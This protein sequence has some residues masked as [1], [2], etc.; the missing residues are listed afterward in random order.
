MNAFC[1]QLILVL[2]FMR[3][4]L[5]RR[6][7]VVDNLSELY[8]CWLS[9]LSLFSR[10]SVSSS[11]KSSLHNEIGIKRN[12]CNDVSPLENAKEENANLNTQSFHIMDD[13]DF[14]ECT[15]TVNHTLNMYIHC[16]FSKNTGLKSLY[17]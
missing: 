8:M 9:T 11:C 13:K 5:I 3:K 12:I 15:Y 1:S 7:R 14:F 2:L 6:I 17:V 16:S 4:K 10:T